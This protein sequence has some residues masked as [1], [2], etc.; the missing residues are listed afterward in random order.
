MRWTPEQTVGGS[1]VAPPEQPWHLDSQTDPF[2]SDP[3]GQDTQPRDRTV[4]LARTGAS[5]CSAPGKILASIEG[6]TGSDLR[7]TLESSYRLDAAIGYFNFRGCS[8]RQKR[9]TLCPSGWSG[10]IIGIR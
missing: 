7:E 3:N 2:R 8:C 10:T 5:C 9:W 4:L 1:L 6:E